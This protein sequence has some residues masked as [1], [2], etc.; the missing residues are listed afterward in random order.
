M[1]DVFDGNIE[2]LV[3]SGKLFQPAS[4]SSSPVRS[5]SP[6]PT[7]AHWPKEDEGYD[8]DS[9]AERRQ[10]IEARIASQQREED[11]IGMGPGRTGVKGV[12]RDRKEAQSLAR[13]KQAQKVDAMNRAMEKASL[14]G[15]TWAEEEQLRLAEKAREEGRP[16]T[17]TRNPF[18]KG[19]FGHLREVGERTFVQAVESEDSQI[20]VVIHIYDPS[21]DRCATLDETL[22]RLARQY[23]STKFLR[24]RAG[25]LGFATAKPKAQGN[26]FLSARP[27]FSLR[28]TPSR[29]ILVPGGYNSD[30]EDDEASDEEK[31]DDG[32]GDDDVD[33]DV[34]PTLLVYRAGELVHSWI[35]V[36]WEASMGIEE[37]LKKHHVLAEGAGSNGNLGFPSDDEDD[38]VVFSG[39]DDG[40]DF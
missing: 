23:P 1:P 27:P 35:R 6:S 9:D 36:D 38:D 26:N 16:S 13:G 12:I 15:L 22:S 33:T 2:D 37:L 7:P 34:L 39:S 29:K 28:R 3:L 31:S 8:Y 4:R 5:R 18:S 17:S 21:L 10:A 19:R 30:D 40:Y 24:A 14:G 20:W 32:W 11:S 25:A